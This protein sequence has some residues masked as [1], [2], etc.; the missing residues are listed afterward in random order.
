[1]NLGLS[2]STV[3]SESHGMYKAPFLLIGLY[4]CL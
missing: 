4:Q 3:L 2:L 1:M